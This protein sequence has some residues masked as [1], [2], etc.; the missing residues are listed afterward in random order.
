MKQQA[1]DWLK[2]WTEWRRKRFWL[3]LLVVAWTLF[4]FFGAP[5][6]VQRAV[7]ETI[8]RSGRSIDITDV[9]TNPYV[10]S[11]HVS[12]LEI[13]DPDE[14]LVLG[15]DELYL[16]FQLSSLFR[17]AWTF[18]EIRLVGLHLEEER[19]ADGTTR[20]ARLSEDLAGETEEEGPA[21]P[22]AGGPPRVVIHNLAVEDG[23]VGFTD[24]LAGGF[25]D[26][27][28]PVTVSASDLRTIPDHAGDNAVSIT[29]PEGGVIS[30]QG[31]L[32]LVPLA[33]EGYFTVTGKGLPAA[34]RYADH[35]L[36]LAIAGEEIDLRF[37]YSLETQD[38]S[39]KLAVE[40]LR[41]QTGGIQV[42]MDDQDNSFLEL[43]GMQLTGGSVRWPEQAARVESLTING[44]DLHTWLD[45]SGKLNLLEAIPATEDSGASPSSENVSPDW[46]ISLG[47]I[48]LTNAELDFEDRT[49]PT[50]G[51]VRLESL[52][53]TLKGVDNQTETV[54]PTELSFGFASGGTLSYTGSISVLPEFR[55]NGEASVSHF[56][57]PD[58][59][60]WLS[61]HARI[62]LGAGTLDLQAGVTG[63]PPTA[64][65]LE[66]STLIEG[67]EMRDTV[68]NERLAALEALNI[69]RF[70]LDL[71]APSIKTSPVQLKGAYGRIHI[72]E[73]LTTNLDGLAATE[74]DTTAVTEDGIDGN[75]T[76]GDGLGVAI[77]GIDIEDGAMDFADDTLPLPFST[78]IRS[79]DGN[80]STLSTSSS[81]PSSVN[82][83]GQVDEFGEARIEGTL[84]PWDFTQSADISM[85]FRN[86][87]MSSLTPYTIQYAGYAIEEGRLDL[88]LEYVL[89]RRKLRGDNNVVV[90]QLMLG[91]KVGTP[92]G[93]SLPLKLAVALLTDSQGVIDVDLPVSGDLDDPTFE[94]SGIVWKAI[95]NLI[96]R[97][98]TSPFRFLGG[99]VG[100]ESE[101]FG[102]LSFQ[103]GRA[104]ITP[105][106]REQLTKLAE[107]MATRPE[108]SLVIRGVYD[109]EVDRAALR[110]I[111][112]ENR[113]EARRAAMLAAGDAETI[114]ADRPALEALFTESFPALS[115]ESVRARFTTTP[116]GGD[117][118][119]AGD[120]VLDQPAY[121]AEL[122]RRLVEAEDISE[123]DLRS[124]AATRAQAVATAL[125]GSGVAAPLAVAVAEK[126][127]AVEGS[128]DAVELELEVNVR[129]NTS[130]GG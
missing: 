80:L 122:R 16:N 91:E 54:I 28:G 42:R 21:P 124:L 82:L 69:E 128:E 23:S 115:P 25:S 31:E 39:V 26:R 53:L 6:L 15:F 86:L 119:P 30:W 111:A 81:E 38:G 97:I 96:T 85:I 92:D 127:R 118:A 88:D 35:F 27:F 55:F 72:Y 20:L 106:D 100:V 109:D 45:E 62:D 123:A 47:Q 2:P 66:G 121:L 87:K 116:T 78:S 52:G 107:A 73:D 103:A 29:T 79:L 58:L 129:E 50:P 24:Q 18:D 71:E 75:T 10:L 14:T 34:L 8:E 83:A 77:A 67:L 108:L 105:P 101:D 12:G 125:K 51:H 68:R 40:N 9:A 76:P 126:V 48:V 46:D 102:T 93:T 74:E 130:P 43:T 36:P 3:F 104:D 37:D 65:Q 89:D 22:E 61:Q 57:L 112:F 98:V 11:L 63:A 5:P 17:R 94:I 60:P 59:Q 13:R 49:L 84:D 41:A 117:G 99:L 95:G 90:R 110:E 33:S 1:H 113:F 70:E 19:F 7:T 32:R 44:P 120:P 114:N 56:S 4:G 64:M